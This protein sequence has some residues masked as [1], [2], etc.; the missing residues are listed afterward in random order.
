MKKELTIERILPKFSL[1]PIANSSDSV[2]F[3]KHRID[4]KR[5]VID[6]DVYLPTRGKNL[7]RGYVWTSE[8]KNE[9]LYS[10]FKSYNKSNAR[11]GFA[12][13]AIIQLNGFDHT[14]PNT[15]QI[16][17]GKQRLSTVLNF[18]EG[19]FPF[20]FEGDEYFYQE[21]NVNLKHAIDHFWFNLLTVYSYEKDDITDQ[22]KTDWFEILNFRGTPQEV[23][24]FESIKNPLKT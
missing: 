18:I 21:L 2:L 4:E 6:F 14:K 15:W 8:Q 9:F 20:M 1:K 5:L 13:I 17:D 11:N 16:I 12:N 10:V 22:Q 7:Q 24:H 3:I 19:K 23:S